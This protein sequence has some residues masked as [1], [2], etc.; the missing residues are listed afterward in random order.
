VNLLIHEAGHVIFMPFGEFISIA[1]G[2]LFQLIVP[3]VFAAYF[4]RRGQFFSA[5]LVL[6]WL[7]ESM[8]N[9]AARKR[10]IAAVKNAAIDMTDLR[11]QYVTK[12]PIAL[13][14]ANLIGAT[15][16]VGC[17][18]APNVGLT[19][20]I[21]GGWLQRG[22]LLAGLFLIIRSV[23]LSLFE[24]TI[25]DKD[26][27]THRSQFGTI[28]RKSYSQIREVVVHTEFLRVYFIDGSKMKIRRWRYTFSGVMH[29]IR[30][31]SPDCQ[32]RFSNGFRSRY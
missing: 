29:F 24:Q 22:L 16:I 18:L 3:A 21:E 8:L 2:S 28:N 11:D 30:R 31:Q 17:F 12:A 32:I 23:F 7:G 19:L 6:F 26:G 15:I 13:K 25:F 9:V 20:F 1:G 27:I 14:L 5:A 4:F 10:R